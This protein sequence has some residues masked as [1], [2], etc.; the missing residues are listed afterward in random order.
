MEVDYNQDYDTALMAAITEGFRM[1]EE[2]LAAT[3][4]VNSFSRATA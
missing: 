4:L 3:K 1:T 2:H